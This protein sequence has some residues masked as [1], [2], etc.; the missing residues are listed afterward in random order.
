[1]PKKDISSV[2]TTGITT[3][4]N[5]NILITE[6][7]TDLGSFIDARL[8]TGQKMTDRFSLKKK[9]KLKAVVGGRES[10]SFIKEPTNIFIKKLQQPYAL[11]QGL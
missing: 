5:N 6:I 2:A 10:S 9:F 1:M 8:N 11:E 3:Q 4:M 7:C